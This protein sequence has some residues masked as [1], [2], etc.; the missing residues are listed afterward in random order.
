MSAYFGDVRIC[1]VSIVCRSGEKS[2]PL[3]RVAAHTLRRSECMGYAGYGRKLYRRIEQAFMQI[4]R[5]FPRNNRPY[6]DVRFSRREKML[7]FSAENSY[8][9]SGCGRNCS[10]Q[11]NC[12]PT[13]CGPDPLHGCFSRRCRICPAS[14]K[15]DC[16]FTER[17]YWF[18]KEMFICEER[19]II[20]NTA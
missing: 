17:K 6:E 18:F 1:Q 10:L 4:W 8:R 20:T 16:H 5:L 15:W 14:E 12:A 7:C 2:S 19:S 3:C 9:N 13:A 11:L